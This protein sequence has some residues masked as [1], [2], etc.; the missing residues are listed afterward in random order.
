MIEEILYNPIALIFG[1]YALGVMGGNFLKVMKWYSYFENRNYISDTL[2]KRL[3]VLHFGWL[4]KNSFMRVFNPKIKYSGKANK[5]KLEQ[6]VV[7]MTD[8]EINHLMGFFFLLVVNMIAPFFGVAC[9][10][11]VVL[12]VLNIIFNFYLVFLQ[13]YNKRRIQKVLRQM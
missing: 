9:W 8:A 13:Q 4:I 10:Y 2:T 6:V 7:E 12:F 11:L 3:G 5:E 1:S